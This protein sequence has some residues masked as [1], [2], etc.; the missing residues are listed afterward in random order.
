MIVRFKG[1]DGADAEVQICDKNFETFNKNH[2][3]VI[4]I[5]KGGKPQ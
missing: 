3:N 4:I 1:K 2:T 5:S